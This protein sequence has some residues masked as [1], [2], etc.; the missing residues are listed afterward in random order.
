MRTHRP[1]FVLPMLVLAAG[2]AP[3]AQGDPNQA[4]L[5]PSVDVA[6]LEGRI[7]FAFGDDGL[8]VPPSLVGKDGALTEVE[9]TDEDLDAGLP[10]V[11]SLLSAP[12]TVY[13]L[14][15]LHGKV[16]TKT[17]KLT[18]DG[19]L[20]IVSA[21][22]FSLH[23][24]H[25]LLKGGSLTV[26]VEKS[27]FS[28]ADLE[29]V[30]VLAAF[31]VGGSSLELEGEID[32]RYVPGSISF[33]GTLALREDFDYHAGP[34]EGFSARLDAGGKVVVTVKASALKNAAFSE[35]E[36]ALDVPVPAAKDPLRLRGTLTGR[37]R[38]GRIDFDGS[39]AVDEPF[40]Y[41]K[42]P[43]TV[44]LKSGAAD[45]RVRDDGLK[46]VEFRQ[47]DAVVVIVVGEDRLH[48]E[49]TIADG[50]YKPGKGVSF[51]GELSLDAPFEYEK[52]GVKATLQPGAVSVTLHEGK[53]HAWI[54]VRQGTLPPLKIDLD[55]EDDED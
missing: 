21:S 4:P 26:K 47:V 5:L 13:A 27:Q 40:V 29:G 3:T 43:V 18:L 41:E 12:G 1:W 34:E 6:L 2:A 20:S 39:L 25:A 37:Y 45:V 44:T 55:D 31:S 52:D 49:G 50:A 9:I 30:A 8:L 10:S 38:E 23:D 7:L 17:K 11:V 19:A 53:K 16:A 22:S 36:G 33:Q 48:L 54:E 46:P 51:T 14:G 35:I 28:H 24:G 15:D 42:G 32:G